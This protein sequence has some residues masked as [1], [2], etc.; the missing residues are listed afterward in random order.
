[1]KIDALKQ[2]QKLNSHV[3]RECESI[4]DQILNDSNTYDDAISSLE[5]LE[6]PYELDK[7]VYQY[8]FAQMKKQAIHQ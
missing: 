2:F 4:A 8:I 5:L 3:E 1:M 6:S 7:V